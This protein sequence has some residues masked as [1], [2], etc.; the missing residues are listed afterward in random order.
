VFVYL[1]EDAKAGL[2]RPG[3]LSHAGYIR[4]ALGDQLFCLLGNPAI[5][6][7]PA[8]Y[9][10]PQVVDACFR[11]PR[12]LFTPP[13]RYLAWS[14]PQESVRPVHPDVRA[15][16]LLRESMNSPN[17]VAQVHFDRSE[18]HSNPVLVPWGPPVPLGHL[19]GRNG[20]QMPA[21]FRIPRTPGPDPQLLP[22]PRHPRY[23]PPGQCSWRVGENIGIFLYHEKNRVAFPGTR[24]SA[25][26]Y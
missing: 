24:R 14:G 16:Q 12:G 4:G 11:R 25:E 15:I 13:G 22:C 10:N 1:G 18:N 8:E 5:P 6:D 9:L 3:G 21:G 23:R 17:L 20:G 19:S 26:S 7:A 2:L